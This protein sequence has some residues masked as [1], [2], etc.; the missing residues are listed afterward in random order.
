MDG[1]NPQWGGGGA[2]GPNPLFTFFFTLN[3][4]IMSKN[5]LEKNDK[6]MQRKKT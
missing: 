4:K 3:V 6:T 2:F 1:F 5:K